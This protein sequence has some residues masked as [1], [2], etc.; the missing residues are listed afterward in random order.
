MRI[1]RKRNGSQ[2]NFASDCWIIVDGMRDKDSV[3]AMYNIRGE[4]H[5]DYITDNKGNLIEDDLVEFKTIEDAHQAL[6]DNNYNPQSYKIIKKTVLFSNSKNSILKKRRFAEN[7]HVSVIINLDGDAFLKLYELF[8]SN[9][10]ASAANT[11][12]VLNI[13]GDESSF[14]DIVKILANEQDTWTLQELSEF[15][16]RNRHKLFEIAGFSVR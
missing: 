13:Y 5:P 7:P 9:G 10:F 15:I 3:Q 6:V 1:I 4:M 16:S 2:R 8:E 11:V 12:K 14:E